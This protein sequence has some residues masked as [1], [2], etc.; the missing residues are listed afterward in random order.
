MIAVECRNL[1]QQLE[2]LALAEERKTVHDQLEQRRCE[3]IEVRD[4][5]LEVTNSLK[6]ISARTKLVGDLDAEKCLDRVRK[7]RESLLDDPLS[8]TKGRQFT[9]MRKAFEKFAT[10]G[11][12]CAEA[13]WLQFM[14]R[15]RPS[16]DP[17][18]VAQAE[19]QKDFKAIAAKLKNREKYAEQLAK[20]PPANEEDFAEIESTWN[21]IREMI[22]AL[23]DVADDPV[24]QEFL[25]AA[26]SSG[27]AS[28]DLLTDEVRAWLQE[29]KIA[30]KY[31][32]TTM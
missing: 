13:T 10:D 28:I 24:V 27:G 18:Q 5:L 15:A 32:I 23:P 20:K 14:P 26:N 4:M 6:A 31:R 8:I 21:D 16:V 30:D 29:N 9:D 17:T 19:Q 25:K 2:E 3:L 12:A 11:K 7:I 22:A 1:R